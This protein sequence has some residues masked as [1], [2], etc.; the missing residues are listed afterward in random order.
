MNFIIEYL[1]DG[2]VDKPTPKQIAKVILHA[3]NIDAIQPV[4]SRYIEGVKKFRHNAVLYQIRAADS[5]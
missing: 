1:P 2:K 4:A 5:Y 3:E